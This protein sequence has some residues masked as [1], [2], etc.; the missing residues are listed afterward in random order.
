[1]FR[2]AAIVLL[3]VS[4]A[5]A[6]AAEPAAGAIDF[7]RHVVGLLGKSGCSAGACHGSFQGKGGLRL[8]LFGSEPERDFLALTRGGG[9]RR[10]NPAKPDES[11]ILL[12]ATGAIPHGGGT[13]FDDDSLEYKIVSEWIAEGAVGPSDADASIVGL[14]I[15][16]RQARPQHRAPLRRGRLAAELGNLRLGIPVADEAAAAAHRVRRVRGR[17]EQGRRHKQGYPRFHVQAPRPDAVAGRVATRACIGNSGSVC[18]SAVWRSKTRT[19]LMQPCA[20][21][22]GKAASA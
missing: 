6:R 17:A 11:L 3:V 21:I 20:I 15:L 7:E 10:V 5:S 13:R 1:M 8:S 19:D 12:K 4:P 22:A 18:R 16:P 9:G 2:V 14:E